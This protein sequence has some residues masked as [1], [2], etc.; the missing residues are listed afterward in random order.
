KMPPKLQPFQ[1]PF[2]QQRRVGPDTLATVPRRKTPPPPPPPYQRNRRKSIDIKTKKTG[3]GDLDAWNALPEAD[4]NRIRGHSTKLLESFRITKIFLRCLGLFPFSARKLEDGCYIFTME[5]CSISYVLFL[6]ISIVHM[7]IFILF[8]TGMICIFVDAKWP[9]ER[10]KDR[11]GNTWGK[12]VLSRNMPAVVF[13]W[14]ELMLTTAGN[15]YVLIHGKSFLKFYNHVNEAVMQLD[16][17]PTT[18][19]RQ[20]DVKGN[21]VF[22]ILF[23][24][25]IGVFATNVLYSLEDV[26]AFVIEA[27]L[28]FFTKD[29][30]FI[31]TE[32]FTVRNYEEHYLKC[33]TGCLNCG[34][35]DDEDDMKDKCLSNDCYNA[36]NTPSQTFKWIKWAGFFVF[37]YSLLAARALIRQ[38]EFFCQV[39]VNLTSVWNKRFLNYSSKDNSI[40][41]DDPYRRRITAQY[42]LKDHYSIVHLYNATE[43]NF[44]MILFAY[45]SSIFFNLICQFYYTALLSSQVTCS[46]AM[47]RERTAAFEGKCYENATTGENVTKLVL[48]YGLMKLVAFED[49]CI[50]KGTMIRHSAITTIVLLLVTLS[51]FIITTLDGDRASHQADIGFYRVRKSGYMTCRTKK[52]R[53][54]MHSLVFS[55]TGPK[56]FCITAAGFFSIRKKTIVVIISV[57]FVYFLIILSFKPG[58]VV[59]GERCFQYDEKRRPI[60]VVKYPKV[61]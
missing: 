14:T 51:S 17:D 11:C 5:R 35:E 44:S 9:Y 34:W 42:M 12:T 31:D 15:L 2:P 4:Q 60:Y 38:F 22:G 49:P 6:L 23:V 26:S 10:A 55:F 13:V 30:V 33:K 61:I 59:G 48:Q 7:V 27:I 24:I 25:C 57:A 18:G 56:Q 43:V 54:A 19:M 47:R 53:N 37:T 41:M 16:V 39:L 52:Q 1:Q 45:Y 21:M 32:P 8:T 29:L 40:N 28:F 58:M 20:S 46:E 50:K 36:I 3:Y